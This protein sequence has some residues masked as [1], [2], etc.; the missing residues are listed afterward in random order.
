MEIPQLCERGASIVKIYV[1]DVEDWER[2]ILMGELKGE[3]DVEFC[4]HSI[5]PGSMEE[6]SDAE[7]LSPFIYSELYRK[8]LKDLPNLKLIA[9][10]STG[11]DHIDIDYCRERGITVCNVPSYGDNTVAE[12]V[13]GL[14]L[15]L[16]HRLYESIDRTRKGDFSMQGLR[17]FDL[18]EKTLGVIGTGSIGRYVIGIALGFHMKVLAFDVKPDPDLARETGFRYVSLEELLA[19]ADIVTLHVPGGEKTAHLLSTEEFASMKKGTVLINTSRGDVVDVKALLKGITEGRVAAAALDV[20][21]DEPVIRE[22]AELLRSAFRERHDLST[23]LADHILLRLRNV[24]VTPHSAFNT[25]EAV[26]RIL[27]TT[28]ENIRAF[29]RGEPQNTVV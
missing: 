10:R 9:T 17:G 27:K 2:D 26:E 18:R 12:H 29:E 1:C 4:D 3:H 25:R 21:P 20:L 7:I 8:V 22:E 5:E 15:T 13:F 23:L 14:M 19:G 28:I 6:F 11:Y 16:S 24:I